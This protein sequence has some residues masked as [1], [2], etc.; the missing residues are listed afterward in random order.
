MS[1]N[2]LNVVDA[3]IAKLIDEATGPDGK[4]ELPPATLLYVLDAFDPPP[5]RWTG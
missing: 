5:I 4:L 2:D 1:D 3:E